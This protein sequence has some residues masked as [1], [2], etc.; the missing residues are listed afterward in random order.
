MTAQRLDPDILER[1]LENRRLE[2]INAAR[3]FALVSGEEDLLRARGEGI[4]RIDPRDG[5]VIT[6][7][8]ARAKRPHTN[9]LHEPADHHDNPTCPICAGK[10]TGIIDVAPL[11]D[12]CT[13]INK[14]LFPVVHPHDSVPADLADWAPPDLGGEAPV[15]GLH[16]LQWTSDFDDRDWH[17]M[18]ID[19]LVIVFERL[20]ALERSLLFHDGVGPVGHVSIIK[21]YGRMVGGSLEHGHQQILYSNVTPPRSA[22]NDR[23]RQQHGQCFS[24]YL[25]DHCPPELLLRR[26]DHARLVVPFCIRR[27]YGMMLALDHTDTGYLHHASPAQLRDL[28]Q[29][30]QDAIRV[31]RTVMPAIGRATAYNIVVHNGP[32]C[33]LYCE[34]LPY[35]QETGGLEQLG[36]WVCQGT[37]E[38]CAEVLRQSLEE[39]EPL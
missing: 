2:D 11:S 33:G 1:R 39:M 3:L 7:N 37:P 32:G 25:I 4:V 5:A 18:P 38:G 17:N 29:G 35:T 28:A 8:S 36:F 12:G 26:Y 14:N 23:F 9:H 21:N 15:R 19:D 30:W 20:A 13:F 10:T 24:R 27:P 31:M 6:Y 34:F 22:D 16:L